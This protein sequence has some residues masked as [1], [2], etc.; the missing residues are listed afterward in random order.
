[1]TGR[2]PGSLGQSLRITFHGG[3]GTLAT[4]RKRG[5]TVHIG[6]NVTVGTARRLASTMLCDIGEPVG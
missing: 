3:I 6:H 2:V 5:K 1:M 4:T